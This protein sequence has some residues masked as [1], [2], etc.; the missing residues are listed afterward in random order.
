MLLR[1]LAVADKASDYLSSF[2]S[3]GQAR[4]VKIDLL[5]SC[6]DLQ[7][8]YLDFLATQLNKTLFY[9]NGNHDCI[10]PKP[11][12]LLG[13]PDAN[14][15]VWEVGVNVH[16][17]VIEEKGVLLCGFAGAKSH[18]DALGFFSEK[19]MH[20]AVRKAVRKIKARRLLDRA[21]NRPSPPVV[22]IS[23]APPLG[24]NDIR[25]GFHE[26]FECFNDF[27][28]EIQPVLWLHGHIHLQAFNQIQ[29]SSFL[30]TLVVNAFEFKLIE[31]S[32]TALEV[33][34]TFG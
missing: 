18:K 23:H 3:S 25:G 33:R 30:N 27:I 29:K 5:L 13:L 19:S 11:G 34:Y 6:G 4:D 21:R 2:V 32:E 7:S 20:R 1:I 9:V 24:H 28:R 31:W 16:A 12:G 26:G 15:S 14:P 8:R 10:P 17:Q 22:V